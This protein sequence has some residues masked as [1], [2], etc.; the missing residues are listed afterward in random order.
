M[1]SMTSDT[2]IYY[3]FV[4]TSEPFCLPRKEHHVSHIQGR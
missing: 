1:E 4:N 3:G 2:P